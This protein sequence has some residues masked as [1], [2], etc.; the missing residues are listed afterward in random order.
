MQQVKVEI[1][2]TSI[3]LQSKQN[4]IGDTVDRFQEFLT[5]LSFLELGYLINILTGLFTIL[6]LFNL[7]SVFYSGQIIAYFNLESR[8][9]R[10]A[11]YF[12]LRRKFQ[13]Y[14]FTLNSALIFITSAILIIVNLLIWSTNS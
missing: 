11:K 5:S 9:P 13:F 12:S 3:E 2:R 6:C 4:F 1:T 7:M 8:Y 10:L 14:Y